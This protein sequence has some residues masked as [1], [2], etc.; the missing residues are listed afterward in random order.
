MMTGYHLF[1]ATLLFASSQ[2][3]SNS[4]NAGLFGNCGKFSSSC[5][6]EDSV[7]T[8]EYLALSAEEKLN[9]IMANINK[10]TSSA[11]WYNA[12]VLGTGILSERMCPTFES[13]KKK[14]RWLI[15]FKPFL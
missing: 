11:E 4:N 7:N 6:C 8:P 15:S 9:K 12:F 1:I 5:V 3:C 10:D 2:S 14:L 13:V